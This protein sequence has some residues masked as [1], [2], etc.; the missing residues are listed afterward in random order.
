MS[1]FEYI[2]LGFW[3]ITLLTPHLLGGDKRKGSN[4]ACIPVKIPI[5]VEVGVV[6][7]CWINGN[8]DIVM[9]F[10]ENWKHNDDMVVSRF[11]EG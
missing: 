7:K 6:G 10:L 4:K 8:G 1:T 5:V 3:K 9:M 2:K 11:N